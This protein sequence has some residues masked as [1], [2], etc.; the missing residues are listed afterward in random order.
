MLKKLLAL[1]CIEKTKIEWFLLWVI[2]MF[3]CLLTKMIV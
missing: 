1:Y 3:F 2:S